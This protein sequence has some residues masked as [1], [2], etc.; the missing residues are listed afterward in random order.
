M[1]VRI[2]NNKKVSAGTVQPENKMLVESVVLNDKDNLE[3]LG[4]AHCRRNMHFRK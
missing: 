1:H 3:G 4:N 2:L